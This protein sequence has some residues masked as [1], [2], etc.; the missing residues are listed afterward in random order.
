MR[1]LQ[2]SLNLPI[3]DEIF[4]DLLQFQ[5]DKVDACLLSHLDEEKFKEKDKRSESYKL[6]RVVEEVVHNFKAEKWRMTS[7]T[8]MLRRHT[9][10]NL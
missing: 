5:F 4:D 7:K 9:N 3:I 2:P 1:Y 8:I 6:L 10:A